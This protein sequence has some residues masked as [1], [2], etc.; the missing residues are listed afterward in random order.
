MEEN[1]KSGLPVPNRNY[2]DTVFRMLFREKRELLSM[3]NAVHGTSYDDPE[4]LEVTTL[5]NAV[6]M[7]M[8]NDISCVLGMHMDLYEHQSTVNPNMPLR[9]LFYVSKLLEN[10]VKSQDLYSEKRITLPTPKFVVFY[11]GKKMQPARREYRLSDSFARKD[12]EINLELLVLQINI[13]P[14]YNAKF[15]ESCPALFEYIQ[16]T[17]RVRQYSQ[18]MPLAEAV[19]TAVDNCIREGILSD[20]L[21]KNRSEV[22]PM[23]IFEYDEEKHLRTVRSEGYEDGVAYGTKVGL[24]QGI[25]KIVYHMLQKD[26]TP[27]TISELTGE[28]MEYVYKLQKEYV[29]MVRET[30]KYKGRIRKKGS[31]QRKSLI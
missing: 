26:Q 15:V 2:R 24:E 9:D 13:N 11:N 27:E 20:F 3:F 28:P 8:K 29:E 1:K 6:Y 21:Q 17:D 19:E 18:T 31:D 7:A 10:H 30:G 25:E 12:G 5:E 16:Y 4:E 23:S 14:G 22:I